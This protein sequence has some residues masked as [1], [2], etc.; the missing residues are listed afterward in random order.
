MTS[1]D[2]EAI[3]SHRETVRAYA[4]PSGPLSTDSAH[5]TTRNVEWFRQGAAGPEPRA[6][7]VRLHAR[8]IAE[9]VDAHPN[10]RQDH[11]AIVLAGPPGA[12]KSTVLAEVLGKDRDDWL[13]VDADE[14]KRGLLLAAVEDGSY[15]TS[16]K[17]DL[18]KERESAGERFYPLEL[19][20]LVHEES[21]MIAKQLQSQAM[22]DGTNIVIDTV[23]SSSAIA[24]QLGRDLAGAGYQVEVIDVEVPYELSAQRIADRWQ[25]SYEE[26]ITTG[27]GLGGRWVPSEYARGVYDGPDGRSRPE[28]AAEFLAQT[29]PAVMRFRRFRTPSENASRTTEVDKGRSAR[30]GDLVDY[31]IVQKLARSTAGLA[32][33]RG[34]RQRGSEGYERGR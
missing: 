28:V 33:P 1:S 9:Y 31:D 16:I 2:Q 12:G 25:R 4:K 13:T 11:R 30:G 7:R 18:I 19:A 15:E 6:S 26:A 34:S 22:A 20:S 21:S 17:P 24:Q 3:E 32:F 29:S 5:A 10:R 27:A 23:L 8:L 14:F